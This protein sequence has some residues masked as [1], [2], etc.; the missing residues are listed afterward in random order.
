MASKNVKMVTKGNVLT[1]TVDLSKEAGLST[2]GKNV[3]IAKT[4]GNID[5]PNP[6]GGKEIKIGLNVYRPADE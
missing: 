3:L 2:S 6:P 4:G 1:I 5:V